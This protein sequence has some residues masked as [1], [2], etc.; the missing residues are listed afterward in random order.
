MINRTIGEK[1]NRMLSDDKLLKSFWVEA[2]II[3]VDLINNSPS[4]L[5]D[6]DVAK[7]V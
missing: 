6:G 1:I 5:L 2:M 7:R 4:T 3:T